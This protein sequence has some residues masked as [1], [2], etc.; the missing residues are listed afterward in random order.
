LAHDGA[1]T[2]RYLLDGMGDRLFT[3][4]SVPPLQRA[5][6]RAESLW[7]SDTVRAYAPGV[8]ATATVISTM[9]GLRWFV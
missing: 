8:I 7:H 4:R 3:G 1:G 9:F 5:R 2:D 6:E